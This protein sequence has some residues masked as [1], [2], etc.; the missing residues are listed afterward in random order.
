[1]KGDVLRLKKTG[2]KINGIESRREFFFYGFVLCFAVSKAWGLDSA[3]DSYKL[4]AMGGLGFWLSVLRDTKF[5]LKEY[6]SMICLLVV[7]ASS[8]LFSGKVGVLFPFLL[9]T[10]SKDID[11]E[12]VLKRLSG[13][14]LGV[15]VFKTFLALSGVVGTTVIIQNR[16]FMDN[17]QRY[18]LGY[19]HPNL[20]H[21][22]FFIGVSLFCYT[23]QKL[24]IMYYIVFFLLN[25]LVYK[26]TYSTTGWVLTALSILGFAVIT[27]IEDHCVKYYVLSR[28]LGMLCVV[29]MI[30]SFLLAY[31]YRGDSSEWIRINSFLTGRLNWN[32]MYIHKYSVPLLGQRFDNRVPN[33]L[34]NA[35]IFILYRY[36]II[37]FSIL[38][39]GYVLV[40]VRL[41]K[42]DDIR[43]ILFCFIF[44]IYGF[45][46][47]FI[48]NCFMNFSM[49]FLCE[50]MWEVTKDNGKES[51]NRKNDRC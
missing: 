12:V 22:V 39:V 45:I 49:F 3:D 10:A 44:L 9:F 1:M 11:I 34:D 8:L 5:S 15:L 33:M 36:G 41:V 21:V 26:L 29:P 17:A 25:L 40:L 31:L 35:Y 42:K 38:F 7:G 20:Y 4:L 37:V 13:I 27:L 6:I 2:I 18:D 14:W 24:R 32:Y 47:Q 16:L 28:F 43:K 48:Q 51:K 30:M 50:L 19:G 46:E 23:H